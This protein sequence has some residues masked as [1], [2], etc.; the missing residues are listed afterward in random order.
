MNKTP[1][2][3]TGRTGL[4]EQQLVIL[5]KALGRYPEIEEAV[6]FGSRAKGNYKPGSDIDIALKGARVTRRT[7]V[8][9]RSDLEDS[10][11]PFF[12]DVVVYDSITNPALKEHVDRVAVPILLN[13]LTV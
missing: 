13:S 6:I 8:A 10:T 5:W 7:A 9:L 1:S 4:T 2:K 12:V 11:L 3:A